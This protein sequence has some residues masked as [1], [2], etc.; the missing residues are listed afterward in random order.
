M[1][2]NRI[3]WAGVSPAVRRTQLTIIRWSR[4]HLNR[5]ECNL[6]VAL[7]CPLAFARPVWYGVM[8]TRGRG[9]QGVLVDKGREQSGYQYDVAI[10]GG[11]P[12]GSTAATLLRKYDPSL[13]VLILE[14]EVFPRPHIGESQLP[15][16][17]TVL[18]EMG[19]WDKVE[20]AG[21][22]IKLGASLTWGRDG[23]SWDFDFYPV[24]HFKDEPR[25]ARYEGQRQFTA[26][27]VDRAKYDKLLLDHA[28]ELGADVRQGVKVV[29]VPHHGDRITGLRLESGDVVTARWYLDGSGTVGLFR[30][31][32][33]LETD[34]PKELRNVAF[35]DYWENAEWAVK[36]GVGGTRIQVRSLPH[37]WL[38]FIPMSPTSTSLGFV[39]PAEHYRQSGKSPE[40]IY[41]DAVRAEPSIAA[42]IKNATPR[43]RVEST[44][45][46]SFVTQ[47]L[48][49][50]NWMLMG[51]AAGFADPILSAG[52]TLAHS[53]AREAAHVILEAARGEVD[54]VW[55]RN[56]YDEKNRLNISQHIRFAQYW[57]AANSC[58]TDLQQHCAQIAREAGLR[59]SPGEAWRWLAQGGFTNTAAS[60]V[61]FGSFDLA[62]AKVLVE[63]FVGGEASFTI[64]KYNVF[65]LNLLGAHKSHVAEV[66]NGRIHRIECYR[67]GGV[68]GVGTRVLPLAGP[69]AN[70]IQA[71][72]LSHDGMTIAN[73]I[74]RS[75][76]AHVPEHRR[77]AVLSEHIQ[78]WEAMLQDGWLTAKFEKGR[79]VF[80]IEGARGGLTMRPTAEGL[81]ALRASKPT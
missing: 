10:V 52:M 11:G 44:K 23:D 43:G 31:A 46:W 24:E 6:A 49:G 20:A 77:D 34:A 5:D 16:V 74:V 19:A 54:P 41:H 29:E 65:R 56:W 71:M 57:Y 48:A 38:W 21:F 47:R 72:K 33:G 40:A 78:A 62:S 55:L 18:H 50:E 1:R 61:Q 70:L 22:P 9:S 81:A 45:D 14:K 36:I 60:V 64:E 63:K 2:S 51:E 8:A 32:L 66:G 7:R 80:A 37:G 26:F 59:L 30:R 39:C 13:R 42:L 27:Q 35:W 75:I 4:L 67:R 3:R 79:R 69:Y 17:C 53:S 15:A 25:P 12:S 58:F 73:T 68:G 28:A 76:A